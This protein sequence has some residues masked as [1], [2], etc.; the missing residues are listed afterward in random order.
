MRVFV[1]S[2]F[3]DLLFSM[4]SVPETVSGFS[5]DL[6]HAPWFY[7]QWMLRGNPAL[8]FD[9]IVRDYGDFVHCRGLFEFYLVNHP[10]LV[11]QVLQ[12]THESFDKRSVIYDRFRNAFGNGLVVAEGDRWKRQRKLMQPMFGPI[13]V[14]RYF[15]MMAECVNAMCDR[16]G[17]LAQKGAVFN[18][19]DDMNRITLEI[20]GRALFHQGFDEVASRIG[21]WTHTIN[22]YSSKPP[23]PIIRSYWFPSRINRE[24]KRTLREFDS[25]LREMIAT[26]NWRSSEPDLLGVLMS[27]RHEES[28][29]LMSEREAIEEALGMIIGGHE[30]SSSALT[31]IWYELH[32]HPEVL[33]QLLEEVD[34][35]TGGRPLELRELPQ[36]VYAKMVVEETLRLHP[37][38]WFENRNITKDIELGGT[39]LAKGSLVAFSRYSLHRHRGF[40]RDPERFDPERFRPGTEENK[41]STYASIPFG[42][43]PRICI[44]I[45]FA[46]ME[47]IVVLAVVSQ[48]FR[49]VVDESD[50]HQMSAQLTMAPK[51]GVRVRLELRQSI[52]A[53]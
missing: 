10:S 30:T 27:S 7:K 49:V 6:V 43:G 52:A 5:G 12:E 11:K 23:L 13:T 19:A 48:R 15:D 4:T 50:R 53:V 40:W 51:H 32:E 35:L 44:G 34:R 26:R 18:V 25:F 38:F 45:H 1:D 8:F 9:A 28:G 14:K 42:G 20:A 2:R 17:A 31:W 47:L 24:L 22:D 3:R 29:E 41:R 21:E 36:L 39:R 16:W 37:P 46:M 33:R